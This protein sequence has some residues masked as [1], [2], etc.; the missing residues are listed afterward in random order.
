MCKCVSYCVVCVVFGVLYVDCQTKSWRS[1][2]SMLCYECVNMC[3]VCRVCVLCVVL[4]CV[5]LCVVVCCVLQTKR[6]RV[7]EG[8]VVL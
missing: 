3:V 4:L 1:K 7:Q 8:R 5:V 6:S 2:E